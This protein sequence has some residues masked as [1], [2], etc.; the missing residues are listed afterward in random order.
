VLHLKSKLFFSA[1]LTKSHAKSNILSEQASILFTF[2]QDF[3]IPGA[4]LLWGASII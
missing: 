4:V 3:R 2:S 1:I